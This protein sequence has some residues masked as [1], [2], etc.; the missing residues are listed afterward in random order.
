[1]HRKYPLILVT[2]TESL[3][4]LRRFFTH[5]ARDPRSCYLDSY[6]DV[7]LRMRCGGLAD[8]ITS[9][10]HYAA[11]I[12]ISSSGRL[13]NDTESVPIMLMGAEQLAQFCRDLAFMRL[14]NYITVLAYEFDRPAPLS[15]NTAS[16]TIERL[17][18]DV[19]E[20]KLT[21]MLA[22]FRQYWW[23]DDRFCIGILPVPKKKKHSWKTVQQDSSIFKPQR[24]W[25]T[26][27]EMFTLLDK[28][29]SAAQKV[30]T[31][32]QSR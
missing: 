4:F 17:D 31:R 26:R 9:C 24:P 25:S 7:Y 5:E 23:L 1:M 21:N 16:M 15:L 28:H 8:H 18:E 22:P 12:R 19:S 29:I 13:K 3:D 10:K 30:T 2:L 14:R 27:E 11:H 6:E 32:T 20:D